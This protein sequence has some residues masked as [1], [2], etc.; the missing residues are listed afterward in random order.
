MTFP[1]PYALLR[2]PHTG[3]TYND[4]GI[5]IPTFGTPV[6][7]P[8][9]S[10]APHVVEQGSATSTETVVADLDVFMPKTTVALKDRFVVD[11]EDYDVVGVQDWT[12]GHHGWQPGIVVELQKVT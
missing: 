6:S 4:D 8:V 7:V 11:G 3:D 1:T 5:A 12:K 2:K 10:I 9:I